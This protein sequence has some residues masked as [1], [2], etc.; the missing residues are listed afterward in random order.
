MAGGIKVKCKACGKMADSDEFVLD[1]GFR[2]MVCR[3]CV[4]ERQSREEVHKKVKEQKEDQKKKPAGW[5]AE[6]EQLERAHRAKAENT[7]DVQ[8]IDE[9]KVKYKCP[10]CSYE[11][12]VNIVKNSPANCPY[13][14]TG[15]LSFR[16]R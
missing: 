15:I 10:K 8:R 11:F 3:N 2:M 4:K 16:I 5:D 9:Q 14:G 12:V 7:V 1:P 6:D 13:C